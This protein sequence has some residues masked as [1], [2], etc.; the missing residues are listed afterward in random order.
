MQNKAK[1][2][3]KVS[4]EMP[5]QIIIPNQHLAMLNPESSHTLPKKRSQTSIKL[6]TTLAM[7]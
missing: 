5:I 4:W 3:D 2:V 1:K 7:A 6:E